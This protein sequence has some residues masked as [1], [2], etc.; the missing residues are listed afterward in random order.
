VQTNTHEKY[1]PS[2]S[3]RHKYKLENAIDRKAR[4]I[5]V[6]RPLNIWDCLNIY[7]TPE[8][9]DEELKFSHQR[10][11]VKKYQLEI[12]TLINKLKR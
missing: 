10:A 9:I 3:N 2:K 11:A 8:E 4:R 12:K 6:Q 7:G 5:N 1:K